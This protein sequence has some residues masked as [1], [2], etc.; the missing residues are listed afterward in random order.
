MMTSLQLETSLP[1]V[2]EQVQREPANEPAEDSHTASTTPTRIPHPAVARFRRSA[3]LRLRGN[4]AELGLRAEHCPAGGGGFSSRAKLTA[5]PS[6]LET[7]SHPVHL[8]R[9]RSWCN[10]GHK[11]E[12]EPEV[13]AC[14]E[15][16]CLS[17]DKEALAPKVGNSSMAN[18]KPRNLSL[19]LNGGS[20]I[21]SSGTSSNS[22]NK[23]SCPRTSRT[24]RTPQTPQ[25]PQTPASG[26][27]ATATE[28]PHSCIRQGNCVKA[29]QGKLSTLHESKISPKTPPVTPDSPSTYLDDDLDSMYSFATTTSG[30]STMSCEHPYVARNGTTFSGRKMKYV[31]HCSNYAGQVGPDYLT[32][33]QRA[34]R[35][36]RRLKELL[37][38]ARQDLE[39]KDTELLRLTREV[40]EL[41]LFKASL[42]SPEERS[43][44]S[45]AVTVREAE[46][47][48]SQDVSP[49]VDMVDEGNAK[50]SPRHLSRQ[51]QQQQQQANHSLQAMQMSAEMQSSYADSGHFEDLTMSSVHSKD[52]QTQSEACGTATP[53]GEA[54]VVC[55]A[56]GDSASNLENY[57]LQR[58]ELI[59]MYEHRIEELIRS[60]D[61]ATSDLKRSHN[62]KVEAL[63][64]K[65]AE[66]NTRYSDMVPDYE[67]AKQRI[68]ELEKQLEDLQRKLVEHEEKQNKMYLHMYQ[69]GQEAERISRADQALDLAQRQPESKVSINELLHQLQSTQDELENIRTIYRRLLEAQKNRTHVDP[70]VTLQFLK[71]AIFYFLTDKENSQGHLQAIESI[72]EFTD[73]EKQKISAANRTP[74]LHAKVSKTMSTILVSAKLHCFQLIGWRL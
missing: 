51:Q 70:E 23:E 50:G 64:Q 26:V 33:T 17:L 24:P 5:I 41:R 49:I 39:Q 63:L 59:S 52:S 65:L 55:G 43:A 29:N 16:L 25:T 12:Q 53:D 74:K 3:S 1:A 44:S 18:G 46:L 13:G 72:L 66:C 34:Q 6:S 47:K 31:V 36:I 8:R 69:Q 14:T 15:A 11:T 42:S 20:D 9:N 28:T 58:Q 19:Q 4:P 45:D 48:T 73:A 35:Q 61:S 32:P 57:E 71:S 27:A 30:R 40:V 38:I 10:L 60:Q 54:D 67:Q 56:G 68:R 21:S 22:S 37:C 7:R 62:D 2:E